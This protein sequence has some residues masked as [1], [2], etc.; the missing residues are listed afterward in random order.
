MEKD[1]AHFR[2]VGV[3]GGFDRRHALSLDV[4]PI[5]G[6]AGDFVSSNDHCAIHGAPRRL[7]ESWVFQRSGRE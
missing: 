4:R 3:T 6:L 5:A 1:G 7:P 2:D